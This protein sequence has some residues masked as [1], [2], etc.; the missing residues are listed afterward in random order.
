MSG[1]LPILTVHALEPGRSV[2][3]TDPA[4]FAH[5]LAALHEA[6]FRTVDLDAWIRRGRP[7][8]ERAFALT[9][10]DGLCSVKVAAPI[11]A[12]VGFCAT[13]FLVTG[14]M[15][16]DNA[17][18]GQPGGIPRRPTLA[19]NDLD[20]LV[21]AG[22]SFGSHTCFHPDLRRVSEEELASEL[23]D[24][25]DAI[26]QRLA[27]PCRLLA[28]PYGVSSRKIRATAARHYDAAFGTRLAYA[29]SS[30]DLFDISR[31]DFHYLK[32]RADL[33]LLIEDRWHERLR[34]RNR[35]RQ[36]RRMALSLLS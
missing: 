25:Q 1:G 21:A 35:L 36:A 20:D 29:P 24:S 16:S 17:W 28:Y 3:A 8:L 31:I 19:W 18:P 2:I 32:R 23:S 11:L 5:C 6:G 15:G 12:R 14:R 26:E 22:F 4:W 30:G 9:F 7:E 34:I 33:S 13:A 10:D 27:K